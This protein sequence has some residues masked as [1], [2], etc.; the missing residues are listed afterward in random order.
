MIRFKCQAGKFTN[1]RGLNPMQVKSANQCTTFLSLSNLRLLKVGFLFHSI[2]S[3]SI[4]SCPNDVH[5]DSTM[6]R[7]VANRWLNLVNGWLKLFL[8]EKK[9]LFP[10]STSFTYYKSMLCSVPAQLGFHN[11]FFQKSPFFRNFFQIKRQMHFK[12]TTRD[13]TWHLINISYV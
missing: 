7:L 4:L 3:K 10:P 2:N 12:F 1:S 8:M 9:L 5:N 6:M 11:F 13:P